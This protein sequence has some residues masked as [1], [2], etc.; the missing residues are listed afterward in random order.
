MSP[1]EWNPAAESANTAK[2]DLDSREHI[3]E[4]VRLFYARMLKD[5]ILAPIFVD[6]ARIDL[7]VHLPHIIDYWCKL[8]LGEQ[9]Y[10]RH[11]MNIHRRL[12]ARRELEP[13]DFARWL[14][15]FTTTADYHFA[16]ER[17]ERAKRVA[18][19]IAGNMER[20]LL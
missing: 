8:L 19:S 3:E 12:H 6:V 17:T 7:D 4:F 14:E 9:D 10:Q 5:E 20:S 1:V 13:G 16:G 15:F 11:T 2:P 18:A